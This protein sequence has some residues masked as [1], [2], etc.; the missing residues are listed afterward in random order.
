MHSRIGSLAAVA[1]R[2]G[3]GT[4]SPALA[5]DKIVLGMIGAGSTV[6]WPTYIATE[7]GLYT[8]HNLD[9]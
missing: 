7:K 8:K 4:S 5:A 6:H 2:P 1:V 9:A 3:A